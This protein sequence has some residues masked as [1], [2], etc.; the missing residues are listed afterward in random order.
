MTILASSPLQ[1]CTFSNTMT[2]QAQDAT[3]SLTTARSA[4]ASLLNHQ[5]SASATESTSP[6]TNQTIP[7]RPRKR[8]T[9]RFF[10]TKK[11][12]RAG[13]QCP[14]LHEAP[15]LHSIIGQADP[16]HASEQPQPGGDAKQRSAAIAPPL[17][18]DA[19]PKTAGAAKR[20]HPLGRPAVDQNRVVQRPVPRA[21]SQDPRTFQA[22]QI[23][24]RYNAKEEN[25][26]EGVTELSF[27]MAPSDPD[28]PFEIDSLKCT[29][30][31]PSAFPMRPPSLRVANKEMER[32]YQVNV[33]RGFDVIWRQAANPTLLG[34]VKELDKKLEQ[35]LTAQ[36]ADVIKI[37]APSRALVPKAERDLP[38]EPEFA[39]VMPEEKAQPER[40]PVASRPEPSEERKQQARDKRYDQVRILEHRLGRDPQFARLADGT[41]FTVPIHPRKK[42]SL[43]LP[44]QSIKAVQ[45]YVPLAY[46]VD[47]CSI[48]LLGVGGEGA[49]NVEAAFLRHA[50]ELPDSTLLERINHLASNIHVMA[51]QPVESRTA[52]KL[53]ASTAGVS[54]LTKNLLPTENIIDTE[55]AHVKLIARPIEWGLPS[56]RG[57]DDNPE[58]TS[59]DDEDESSSDDAA[60]G[61]DEEDENRV[62]S[63]NG[64]PGS[65]SRER[66]IMLSFPALDLHNIELLELQSVSLTVKCDRCKDLTTVSNISNN[67]LADPPQLRSERCKKCATQFSLGFRHDIMHANSIR[68]GYLDL[69]GCT[70]FDLLLSPFAP[71][72]SLCSTVHAPVTAVRGDASMAICRECHAHMSFTIR[73]TKF[74]RISAAAPLSAGTLPRKKPKD[75][76]GI[77][78]GTELP[79]TGRCRH[80]GKSHRWF[81]FS[82]CDK[83][84][85]CDRCHDEV[86]KDHVQEFANRMICGFCSREQNYRPEEC[87]ICRSVLTGK[88]G[89]GF[90]EGGKG[91]RDPSKMSR[92][93][94]RKYKRRGGGAVQ[95][96][97]KDK[98]ET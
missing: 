32:G 80:Y 52:T 9:C 66:G 78:A 59:D 7:A 71:T 48:E 69:E 23:K 41:V 79:R 73:E 20:L 74:L 50:Q 64:K 15:Q 89:R 31:L 98:Y 35:L 22:G 70:P 30:R 21:A 45:L 12:C 54:K 47:T 83:V 17:V 10:S 14:F 82:C 25:K 97:L 34:A 39:K 86:E 75:S 18:A 53:T 26:P 61:L 49:K 44:L 1:T 42:D 63:G 68:A 96:N 72:C 29:I 27:E 13:D 85:A 95:K 16:V 5:V 81:R 67:V 62:S 6:A 51:A 43:P 37:V 2:D 8:Q 94:P 56:K 90:W 77:V 33:E 3:G 55:K 87:G 40:Q 88:K 28:F 76:L 38:R 60:S 91:T 36:K 24:R 19:A 11:G 92:K 93:D 46:D 84:Y 4:A 65:E 58:T 57:D